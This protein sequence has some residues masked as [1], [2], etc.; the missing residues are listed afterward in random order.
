MPPSEPSFKG[1]FLPRYAVERLSVLGVI[2]GDPKETNLTS[3]Q[4]KAVAL[5]LALAPTPAVGVG[6]GGGGA[7]AAAAVAG[8]V[9][10]KPQRSPELW[11]FFFE[12]GTSQNS[13]K[14]RQVCALLCSIK[15]NNN[16]WDL[17]PA[18]RCPV[19]IHGISCGR[20]ETWSK[21]FGWAWKWCL[22]D[23]ATLKHDLPNWQY[24]WWVRVR[25]GGFSSTYFWVFEIWYMPTFPWIL[26]EE[27]VEIAKGI[28]IFGSM[29]FSRPVLPAGFVFNFQPL[30]VSSTNPPES[31]QPWTFWQRS[32]QN[33]STHRL[34][35]L[36]GA[37]MGES[38]STFS[39]RD[40]ADDG[41]TETSSWQFF[42]R[43]RAANGWCH[44]KDIRKNLK[45]K[46]IKETRL[47]N[48]LWL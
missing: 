34:F 15:K 39:W 14:K 17:D 44:D 6:V 20:E 8:G 32:L 46:E 28:H 33:F 31:P 23:F 25:I 43:H 48:Y 12:K 5:S 36:R 24:L 27:Y 22:D 30:D 16:E 42:C 1:T 40:V 26:R 18:M 10:H 45:G 38:C 35:I 4:D 41:E 29:C 47:V 11:K 13:H 3:E 2:A 21:W 37:R 7:A 19:S 9:V